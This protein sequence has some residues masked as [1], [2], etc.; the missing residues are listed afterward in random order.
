MSIITNLSYE[1]AMQLPDPKIIWLDDSGVIVYTGNDISIPTYTLADYSEGNP[2]TYYFKD[3][4]VVSEETSINGGKFATDK[5]NCHVL[6]FIDSKNPYTLFGNITVSGISVNDQPK[7]TSNNFGAIVLANVDQA[8]LLANRTNNTESGIRVSY[9]MQ[10]VPSQYCITAFNHLKTARNFGIEHIET[11][12]PLTIGNVI[13]NDGV[14][15]GSHGLRYTAANLDGMRGAVSSA[16]IV[17]DRN[18]NGV[19][20]QLGVQNL[21]LTGSV[22]KNVSQDG[23]RS[24]VP[25]LYAGHHLI[26]VAVLDAGVDGVKLQD[27]SHCLVDAITSGSGGVGVRVGNAIDDGHHLVRVLSK[28]DTKS[29]VIKSSYNYV[30]IIADEC[31]S[32]SSVDVT[33]DNNIV[34]VVVTTGNSIS[35]YITGNDNIIRVIQDGASTTGL[36]I[37]GHRNDVTANCQDTV[38][39]NGNDNR[40]Y[41]RA[42]GALNNNGI[43]NDLSGIFGYSRRGRITATTDVSGNITFDHGLKSGIHTTAAVMV[44]LHGDNEYSTRVS[45]IT[46]TQIVINIK[47]SSGDNVATT[48]VTASWLAVAAT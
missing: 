45:D 6:S 3:G 23:F 2:N 41:G 42:A 12:L 7:A 10:G 37:D 13:H 20:V 19:S 14:K 38:V 15:V 34:D 21:V 35:L 1:E 33:G 39:I 17:S 4:L 32:Y 5:V 26:Q 47:D 40:I 22:I 16:N 27:L 8:L 36:R 28:G 44:S 48:N 31:N 43:G 46:E 29:A 11:H 25:R 9:I 30:T 24:N 18:E